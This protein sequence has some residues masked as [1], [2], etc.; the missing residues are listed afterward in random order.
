MIAAL[1]AEAIARSQIVARAAD[2]I[3]ALS[4]EALEGTVTA[5]SGL[6]FGFF[7]F[8]SLLLSLRTPAHANGLYRGHSCHTSP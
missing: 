4:L 3:C 8:F 1:G 5:Y 7:F 2:V 6:L